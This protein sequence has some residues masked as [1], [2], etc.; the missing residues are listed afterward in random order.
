MALQDGSY[1]VGWQG[2]PE[3]KHGNNGLR[4]SVLQFL[5][6]ANRRSGGTFRHVKFAASIND[7]SSQH[8]TTRIWMPCYAAM[9]H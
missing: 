2:H 5:H 1:R 3:Y 4:L 7:I 8:T 9:R 6:S